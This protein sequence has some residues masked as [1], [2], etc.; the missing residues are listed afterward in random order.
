M[1]TVGLPLL[2]LGTPLRPTVGL[3]DEDVFAIEGLEPGAVGVR[4]GRRQR[5]VLDISIALVSFPQFLGSL[6][7][8]LLLGSQ[9]DNAW[10][11]LDGI[12]GSEI[13]GHH[14]EEE[15]EVEDEKG[16]DDAG[17][18]FLSVQIVH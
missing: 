2:A 18:V 10:V 13:G 9:R 8:G 5:P 14:E 6:A 7:L 11:Q 15:E 3:A 4:V 1:R 16:R 17:L 12:E